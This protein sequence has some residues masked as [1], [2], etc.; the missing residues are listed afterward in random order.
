V[1]VPS[2]MVVL[3]VVAT[4]TLT[5]ATVR[6]MAALAAATGRVVWVGK[7]ATAGVPG[8]MAAR[9]PALAA[10][11]LVVAVALVVVV[12]AA[13]AAAAAASSGGGAGCGTAP[14]R[15]P[16]GTARLRLT[17]HWA[18]GAPQDARAAQLCV[19]VCARERAARDIVG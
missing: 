11:A 19:H 1:A 4:T 8:A 6:V 12:A 13:A 17:G 18:S 14:E 7:M 15:H 5:M 2:L 16:R 9:A 10:R 3:A